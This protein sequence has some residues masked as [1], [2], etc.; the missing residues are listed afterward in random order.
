ME[1]LQVLVLM[2][3]NWEQE[4]NLWMRKNSK[5]HLDELFARLFELLQTRAKEYNTSENIY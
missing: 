2:L 3:V 1:T 4:C 5:K